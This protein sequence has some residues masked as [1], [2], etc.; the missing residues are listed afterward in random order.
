MWKAIMGLLVAASGLAVMWL[1][2]G[3]VT[4]E[5]DQPDPPAKKKIRSHTRDYSKGKG[6]FGRH[7][8]KFRFGD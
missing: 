7:R 3:S 8:G 5:P 2:L 1:G 6:L 4:N